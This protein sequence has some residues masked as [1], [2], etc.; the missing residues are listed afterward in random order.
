MCLI[1]ESGRSRGYRSGDALKAP[2][3]LHTTLVT[4]EARRTHQNISSLGDWM[5]THRMQKVMYTVRQNAEPPGPCGPDGSEFR[6]DPL[7]LQRTD[8]E[9]DQR[10]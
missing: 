7:L 1:G 8:D 4:V 6:R 10:A 9:A 2:A 5:N 3:P